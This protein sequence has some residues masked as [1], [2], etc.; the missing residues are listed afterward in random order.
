MLAIARRGEEYG[1]TL[2]REIG[3]SSATGDQ[4]AAGLLLDLRAVAEQRDGLADFARRVGEIRERHA[5]KVKFLERIDGLERVAQAE[6][7]SGSPE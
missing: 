1:A 4:R 6:A 7:A 2:R 3:R 5:R